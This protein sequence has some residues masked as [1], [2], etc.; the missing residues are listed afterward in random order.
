MTHPREYTWYADRATERENEMNRLCVGDVVKLNKDD[1]GINWV[2]R[3]EVIQT[4]AGEGD[5]WGFRNL[6]TGQ[7]IFTLEKWTAYREPAKKLEA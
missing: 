5:V 7:E 6:D 3:A 4:P 2:D 1:A